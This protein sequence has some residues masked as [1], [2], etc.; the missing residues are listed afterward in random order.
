MSLQQNGS[1]KVFQN[2]EME[3]RNVSPQKGSHSKGVIVQV[4]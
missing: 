4:K 1:G 3:T 2:G